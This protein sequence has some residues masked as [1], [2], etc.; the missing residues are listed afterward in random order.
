MGTYHGMTL[1]SVTEGVTARKPAP[2]PQQPTQVQPQA[3]PISA[4]RPPANVKRGK[5]L[6]A[7]ICTCVCFNV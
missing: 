2:E 3:K 6:T 4:A 7:D 5:Y 1:K